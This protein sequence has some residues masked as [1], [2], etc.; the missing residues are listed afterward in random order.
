[1]MSLFLFSVK[2]SKSVIALQEKEHSENTLIN[3][4][5]TYY[6]R[7]MHVQSFAKVSN[8]LHNAANLP[9]GLKLMSTSVHAFIILYF[10]WY[11]YDAGKSI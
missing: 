5:S 8:Q 2:M 1:M 6:V 7:C 3:L 10:C 4:H 11:F 9:T